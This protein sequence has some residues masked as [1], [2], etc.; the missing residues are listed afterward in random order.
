[1]KKTWSKI[2][3]IILIMIITNIFGASVIA[4]EKKTNEIKSI[5]H[6]DTK[7]DNK[8]FYTSDMLHIEG[9]KLAAE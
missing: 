2:I 1:M 8:T 4:V 3:A 6:I 9:W 7:L 5:L